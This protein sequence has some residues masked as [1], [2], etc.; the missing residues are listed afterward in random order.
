MDYPEG[1]VN[2]DEPESH[3]WM[4]D[5]KYENFIKVHGNRP[6]YYRRINR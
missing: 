4:D 5:P 6:E 1:K 2:S 3:F